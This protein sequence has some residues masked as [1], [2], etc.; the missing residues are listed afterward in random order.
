MGGGGGGGGG[1]EREEYTQ[2]NQIF[3][4]EIVK[5]GERGEN[6][7]HGAVSTRPSIYPIISS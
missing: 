2:M 1:S 4:K 6:V 5:K 3:Q 7:H